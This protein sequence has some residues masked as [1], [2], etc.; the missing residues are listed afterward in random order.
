MGI[1]TSITNT[2]YRNNYKRKKVLLLLSKKSTIKILLVEGTS[3]SF[4]KYFINQNV[5]L[6]PVT[7][8]EEFISKQFSSSDKEALA[9]KYVKIL[10]KKAIEEEN[11]NPPNTYGKCFGIIDKDYDSN[12]NNLR[13]K[14]GGRLECTDYNDL[15]TT[16]IYLDYSN[17]DTYFMST[18]KTWNQSVSPLQK[19]IENASIIGKMRQLRK[20]NECTKLNGKLTENVSIRFRDKQKND[21]GYYNF[22]DNNFDLNLNSYF[23]SSYNQE[24]I[25]D[26]VNSIAGYK[27]SSLF[28]CRG[29]DVFDFLACFYRKTNSRIKQERVGEENMNISELLEDCQKKMIE[30]FDKE[31]FK[32]KSPMYQFLCKL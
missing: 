19:A 32:S 24:E 8:S 7:D 14:Y 31:Q 15:E 28:Y 3:D 22:I 26:L 13:K 12:R 25:N 2:K 9:K 16:L 5:I 23:G 11:N 27:S 6:F 4:Y 20:D 17:I 21:I 1:S 10:V 30:I 29:H 18:F